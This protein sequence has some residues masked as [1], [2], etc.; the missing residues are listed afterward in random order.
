MTPA[1]DADVFEPTVYRVASI[2]REFEDVV[3]LT[4][5]PEG[6][7]R[8]AFTPGQFNMLYTFGVGEAAISICG[9]DEDQRGFVHTVRQ[10]GAV[11]QALASVSEGD[12][13]GLRGPF[14]KGWPLSEAERGDIVFVAGGLGLAPLR[15]AI[16]HVLRHRSRY[17]RVTLLFG[18]RNPRTI[19]YAKDIERWR[20]QADINGVVTV[21]HA[22]AGWRG[23]VGAVPALIAGAPFD[24]RSTVAMVCG[25]E[26]MMRFTV[27]SLLD[28]GL[29]AERIHLSMERNMKCAIGLCGRCQY[30]HDFI[31]KDGPVM[32][33]DRLAN[34]FSVREI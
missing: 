3:T 9:E 31:C 14:G 7:Q 8:P 23:S 34:R 22:D 13:I 6:V 24:P 18:T 4:L 33:Y 19:L 15:P 28:A 1:Q 32:R 16:E 25:P 12:A 26:V 2:V 11:S 30:G 5:H 27:A 21:D 10:V 29:P 20:R 17:R